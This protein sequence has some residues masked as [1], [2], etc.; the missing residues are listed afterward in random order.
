MEGHY[1]A[2]VEK[3]G[4]WVE[5][6]DSSVRQQELPQDMEG[7]V[8]IV[9]ERIRIEEEAQSTEVDLGEVNGSYN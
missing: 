7:I 3:D 2:Y 9:L 6:N 1:M 5:C 8:V 4:R